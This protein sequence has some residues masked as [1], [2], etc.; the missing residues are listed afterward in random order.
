MSD[1]KG[2]SEKVR[3]KTRE[4]LLEII[5]EMPSATTQEIAGSLGLT[6]K[7]VEWNLKKTQIR[8]IN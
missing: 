5:K 8:G 1:A 3:E 4:K 6:A 7:G 2:T